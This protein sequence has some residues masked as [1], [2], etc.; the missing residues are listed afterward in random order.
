MVAVSYT[1]FNAFSNGLATK[2]HDLSSDVLKIALIGSDN[3]PV[4]TNSILTDLTEI[5]YTN[6]V[7]TPNTDRV[8]GL[9]SS[10]QTSGVY[11]LV[12]PDMTITATG[13]SI[14]PFRYVVVYNSTS[15]NNQLVGWYDYG[16]ALTLL[17]YE[18]L[19]VDFSDS[20]GIFS[21]A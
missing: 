14:Q 20:D 11:K 8:I 10:G 19:L 7:T 6:V 15:T 1:K 18:W 21:L 2:Q 4:A 12:L 5:S 13:G 3:P 9:T 16:D 17:Q